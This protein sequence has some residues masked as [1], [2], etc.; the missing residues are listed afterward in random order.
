MDAVVR[1]LCNDWT[2]H[3]LDGADHA[4]HVLRNSGRTDADVLNEI[5]DA[6][7]AWLKPIT[8]PQAAHHRSLR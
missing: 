7:Q 1:R 4:F 2:M 3:W 5:G 6:T 8:R